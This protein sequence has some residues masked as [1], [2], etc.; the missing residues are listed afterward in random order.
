M[1]LNEETI[2][3]LS[4]LPTGNVA[5]NCPDG[6]VMDAGIKA[7]IPS[8]HLIG[9]A[10][11]VQGAPG[12]NLAMHQ[13]IHYAEKGDVLI[14][15]CGGYMHGGH[16]GDMMANA[17][18]RK[19]IQGVIVDGSTR[20]REDILSLSFPLYSRGFC[21]AP[22]TKNTDG[23]IN[24]PVSCGGVLVNPGDLI[25]ADGDGVVVIPQNKEDEIIAKALA[26][27]DHEQEILKDIS[28][29]K[30]TLEIYGFPLIP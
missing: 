4:K 26:K 30:D 19:G 7:L 1:N 16:F 12:D 29:G 15:N 27:Y 3:K 20:D 9:R 21:P 13:G 18:K 2:R 8:L 6:C 5:D 17:C 24:I 11:P 23:K 22:T 10:F 28:N 25:F 14:F